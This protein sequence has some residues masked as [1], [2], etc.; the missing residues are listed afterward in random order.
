MPRYQSVVLNSNKSQAHTIDLVLRDRLLLPLLQ[1]CLHCWH[2]KVVSSADELD[3][4][5]VLGAGFAPFRGGPMRYLGDISEGDWRERIDRVVAVGHFDYD[6][7]L[8]QAWF[9]TQHTS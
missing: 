9:A 6:V 1:A 8:W 5:M 2:T 4:A 7:E 3:M